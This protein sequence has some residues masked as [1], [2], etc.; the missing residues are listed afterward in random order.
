MAYNLDLFSPET[1]E[2]FARSDRSISGFR[3]RQ[4][5]V[6]RRIKPG[7]KFICGSVKAKGKCV[8]TERESVRDRVSP[9]AFGSIRRLLLHRP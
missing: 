3:M 8:I 6:A 1:Y 4:L 2:A 7:D 5:N 9:W